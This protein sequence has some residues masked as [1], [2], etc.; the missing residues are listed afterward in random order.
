MRHHNGTRLTGS[1]RC[2]CFVTRKNDRSGG[3][4]IVLKSDFQQKYLRHLRQNLILIKGLFW[5]FGQIW[6]DQNTE[7][8]LAPRFQVSIRFPN[9]GLKNRL[10]NSLGHIREVLESRFFSG[11][12]FTQKIRQRSRKGSSEGL[13]KY[14]RCLRVETW[15]GTN[16]FVPWVS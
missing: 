15:I 2:R 12:K 7:H 16:V 14:L 3:K 4:L 1:S 9:R 6:T 13:V 11:R 8:I 5:I 10:G